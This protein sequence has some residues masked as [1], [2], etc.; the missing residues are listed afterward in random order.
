ME[1]SGLPRFDQLMFPVI[2]ALKE[3][4]G[5]G[6]RNEII[7]AVAERQRLSDEQLEHRYETT[8]VPVIASRIGWALSWLK[9]LDAVENSRRGV[10]ALTASGRSIASEAEV[11]KRMKV[12]RSEVAAQAALSRREAQQGGSGEEDAD[13]EN[14]LDA[15]WKGLL[16]Q[17]LLEM[18]PDAFE[19]LTQ[20]LLREA[21]FRDVEVLGKS[22]D[23]G[24]DG[25]GVYRLSLVSFPIY[26]QCKRYKGSVSAGTVRDFRGAMAGRGEKGLLVTTGTFTRSAREESSR[27]GAPPVELIDSDDLCGLLRDYELG[28]RTR[29]RQVEDVSVDPDFFTQFESD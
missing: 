20:R 19:R 3:A 29:I 8:G 18:P 4:G 2:E 14:G 24:I 15:E 16:L 25:V 13:P 26:F 1:R 22:G 11:M 12:V 28:V 17:R 9:K 27:D 23:G 10:W 21:G 7:E 5:S 6:L